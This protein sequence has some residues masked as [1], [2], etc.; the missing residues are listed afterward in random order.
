MQGEQEEKPWVRMVLQRLVFLVSEAGKV[1]LC[2]VEPKCACRNAHKIILTMC[3]LLVPAECLFVLY[4]WIS[5][6]ANLQ[7]WISLIRHGMWGL[8]VILQAAG[9]L[10]ILGGMI[11]LN[12]GIGKLLI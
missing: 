3:S 11:F 5:G 6:S 7:L 9:F 4:K 8:K 12:N 1:L 2:C 10:H